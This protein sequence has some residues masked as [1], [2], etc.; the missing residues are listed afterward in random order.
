MHPNKYV[1]MQFSANV[2]FKSWTFFGFTS[3]NCIWGEIQ[4]AT[5]QLSFQIDSFVVQVKTVAGKGS[6]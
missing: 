2:S 4:L 3:V 1:L 6:V 5:K